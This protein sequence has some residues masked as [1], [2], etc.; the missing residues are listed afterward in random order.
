MKTTTF[1]PSIRTSLVAA[2][3]LALFAM[4]AMA[5][6]DDV[7]FHKGSKT[8]GIFAGTGVGYSYY[9]DAR[10]P[11]ALGVTYDQGF[12]DDIG[13]GNIGIGGVLAF[14]SSSGT[15]YYGKTTYTSFILGVRGTYHL[16]I[17]ADKNNKFDPYAGVTI[18]VSINNN[19]YTYYNGYDYSDYYYARNLNRVTPI[20]GAF[21]GAKYNFASNVG[22]FAEAGYD[23]TFI[24][25]GINFNF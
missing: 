2:A 9:A 4:P 5:Q 13:P 10:V 15:Y 22:V 11:V 3:I 17:L 7:P 8:V 16:T 20:A 24:R 21:V 25:G 19:S 6:K 18:G 12:F 23:F 14:K 1:T